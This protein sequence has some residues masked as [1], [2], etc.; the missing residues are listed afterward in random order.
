MRIDHGLGRHWQAHRFNPRRNL[1]RTP[2]RIDD[3]VARQHKRGT[4]V[5]RIHFYSAD[6]NRIAAHRL[7]ADRFGPFDQFDVRHFAE[8]FAYRRLDQHAAREQC[9]N[10]IRAPLGPS[11]HAERG[12]VA[13]EIYIDRAAFDHRALETGEQPVQLDPPAHQQR[14]HM[15]AL[16][17]AGPFMRAHGIRVA[18][19]N[20]HLI[21]ETAQ[22]ARR[23][24]P[25]HAAADNNCM[26]VYHLRY[27]SFESARP[28]VRV[29]IFFR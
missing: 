21:E 13:A 29:S 25:G 12:E 17:N 18:I 3:Q 9:R 6:A 23:T 7:E 24:K 19:D 22:H 28:N 4:A 14:M 1:G 8:Q 20:G 16:R 10:V 27:L 11:V 2:A 5:A 15:P 26:S